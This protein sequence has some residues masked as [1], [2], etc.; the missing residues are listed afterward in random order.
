MKKLRQD[1]EKEKREKGSK[2]EGTSGKE[3]GAQMRMKANKGR[4]NKKMKEMHM[5]EEREVKNL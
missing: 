3:E 4:Y 2:E 1:T 5:K